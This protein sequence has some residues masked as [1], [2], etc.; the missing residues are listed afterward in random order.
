MKFLIDMNLSSGW[1][2]LLRKSGWDSV[3]WSSVGSPNAPDVVILTFAA[4]NQYVVLTHDLDFGAVLAATHGGKPSVVQVRS[5]DVNPASIGEHVIAA[6]R[7]AHRELEEGA[8]LTVEPGRTRLRLLPL[9]PN[10]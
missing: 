5:D 4:E 6:L 2:T 8:L 3:H 1:V 10:Q 9:H 7:L